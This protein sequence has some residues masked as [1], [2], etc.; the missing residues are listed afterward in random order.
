MGDNAL[1]DVDP[2]KRLGMWAVQVVRG[3]KH[4]NEDGLVAPDW[5][6]GNFWELLD[7][8]RNHMGI[9]IP[10]DAARQDTAHAHEI[11]RSDRG[12]A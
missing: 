1:M 7:I 3:G 2:P 6:I 10:P 4:A 11:A 8:L 5:K 9:V 12:M